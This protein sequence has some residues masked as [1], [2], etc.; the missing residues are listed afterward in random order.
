MKAKTDTN[1][2]DL[3]LQTASSLFANKGYH[4][5]GISEILKQSHAPKGSLYYYF[6]Q[7]KEQLADEALQSAEQKITKGITSFLDKNAN[8]I[9]AFQK[10]LLFIAQ[11]IEKDMFRPNVSISLIALET[12][13][14]SERI[15]KRCEHIFAHIE[16]LY[17][18]KLLQDNFAP[19]IASTLAMTMVMLTEGAITLS[20][21]KKNTEP[22]HRLAEN[23]PQLLNIK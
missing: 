2:K 10:H 6:P 16:D 19:E 21:T 20:L 7:G 9:E 5:T 13:S 22:L 14:S 1:T 3:F 18:Q 15:R 4:A 8:A 12:F 17:K 11:K 23:L